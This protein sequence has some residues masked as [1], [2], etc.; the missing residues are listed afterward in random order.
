MGLIGPG[1]CGL[2]TASD[3]VQLVTRDVFNTQYPGS[4]GLIEHFRRNPNLKF[5]AEIG[6]DLREER[7]KA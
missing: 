2:N 6:F 5:N 1:K 7:M 3:E 4:W